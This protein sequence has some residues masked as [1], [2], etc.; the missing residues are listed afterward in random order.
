MTSLCRFCCTWTPRY[1][2][3]FADM[4]VF[5]RSMK[6][7]NCPMLNKFL[8]M[9]SPDM[10]KKHLYMYFLFYF[11]SILASQKAP[12][13]G[14]LLKILSY[15]RWCYYISHTRYT[16]RKDSCQTHQAMSKEEV[17][18]IDRLPSSR[19]ADPIWIMIRFETPF[20]ALQNRRNQSLRCKLPC[21]GCSAL[22]F[23]KTYAICC[24]CY[25]FIKLLF[26]FGLF[27]RGSKKNEIRISMTQT[28][29]IIFIEVSILPK[30]S[31]GIC[32]MFYIFV[33]FSFVGFFLHWR[34]SYLQIEDVTDYGTPKCAD[35]APFFAEW[36]H[37]KKAH[38]CICWF[39]QDISNG[40]LFE[41]KSPQLRE[42]LKF[43]DQWKNRHSDIL[44][45]STFFSPFHGGW[46]KMLFHFS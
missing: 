2:N 6:Y 25:F 30:H 28:G 27:N 41:K 35:L 44:I 36:N 11:L 12:W 13:L 32:H 19:P 29:G 23:S 37:T 43:A 26:S 10:T 33:L 16:Q 45:S 38:L 40:E 17:T 4:C 42:P 18:K 1:S 24:F 22:L 21:N 15:D 39:A 31:H 9:H 20:K 7:L 8:K 5:S 14:I 34:K 3:L 46:R